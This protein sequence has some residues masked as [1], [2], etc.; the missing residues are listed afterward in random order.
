M[1]QRILTAIVVLPVLL[2][3]VYWGI[4]P[5]AIATGLAVLICMSEYYESLRAAGYHPRVAVGVI[6]AFL[7]CAA[8]ALRGFVSVDF[9]GL[10]L[11]SSILLIMTSELFRRQGEDCLIGWALTFI[12]TCYIG[13]LFS[14]YILL[15]GLHTP[16]GSG[17]LA[18][19]HIAPGAAWVYTVMAITWF[20]DA[21]A[22]F[23]GRTFGRHRMA[24]IIS[25]NKSWEGAAAGFA[26]AIVAALLCVPLLGRPISATQ[27]VGLGMAGGVAGPVG[28]IVESLIK[29]RIGLKDMGT[30]VPG[31]GGILDRVDSLLFSAPV[32]YYLIL[33]FT[34][35]G[36]VP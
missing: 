8:S 24:P 15:R 22:Y 26:A 1:I 13:W 12:G 32:I 29:R 28:D 21:A 4:V 2:A 17:W 19:L 9:T 3:V 23:V 7:F 34:G 31:H 18:P 5:V 10:A 30:I 33:I 36:P 14:Y 35:S 11:S 6:S 25:P 16:L 20:E 27:A